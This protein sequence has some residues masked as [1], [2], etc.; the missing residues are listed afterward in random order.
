MVKLKV[1]VYPCCTSVIYNYINIILY[2]L[3]TGSIC[4]CVKLSVSGLKEGI[5]A[6]GL[7][8]L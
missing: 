7:L 3:V 4:R 1:G 8:T 2:Y 6:K 5:W